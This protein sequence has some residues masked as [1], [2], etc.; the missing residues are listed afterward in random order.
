M[1]L[2]GDCPT[3][4]GPQISEGAWCCSVESV[5][6]GG[7]VV[8]KRRS[9]R[10]FVV[11]VSMI[12]KTSMD[13]SESKDTLTETARTYDM[14]HASSLLLNEGAR[15]SCKRLSAVLSGDF[16]NPENLKLLTNGNCY[17][18]SSTCVRKS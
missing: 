8:L 9:C 3:S 1:L 2:L 6:L 14:L 4:Q 16:A 10:D 13:L 11:V 17:H 15:K 12:E 7:E 18:Y 5:V